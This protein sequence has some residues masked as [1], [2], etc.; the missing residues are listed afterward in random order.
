MDLQQDCY[1]VIPVSQFDPTFYVVLKY[2]SVGALYDE[3]IL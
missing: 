3:I 1:I 2:F